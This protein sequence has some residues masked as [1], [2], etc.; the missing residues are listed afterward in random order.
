MLLRD[1]GIFPTIIMSCQQGRQVKK[2]NYSEYFHKNK[3]L[4]GCQ[5]TV[6][7]SLRLVVAVI[8][9]RSEKSPWNIQNLDRK[10]WVN[11]VWCR[12]LKNSLGDLDHG[13][14]NFLGLQLFFWV[15]CGKSLSI[16]TV[17]Y[18]SWECYTY[19]KGW[20]WII[21]VQRPRLVGTVLYFECVGLKHGF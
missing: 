11:K 7:W 14:T 21:M 5:S 1:V 8:F 4:V 19:E 20:F 18:W 13:D 2:C 10:N 9:H 6:N 3:I 17:V 12:S 15:K 16:F